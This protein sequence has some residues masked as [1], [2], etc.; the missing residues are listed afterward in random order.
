MSDHKQYRDQ[1]SI[2]LQKLIYKNSGAIV[3][4]E[5]A[6]E[7]VDAIT[8]SVIKSIEH[9]LTNPAAMPA[10]NT[11]AYTRRHIPLFANAQ[12]EKEPA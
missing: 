10:E 4:R 6:Q 9:F 2:K 1:A 8:L 3:R 5:D 11:K 7:V 12:N